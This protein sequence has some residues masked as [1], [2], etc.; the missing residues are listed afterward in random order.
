MKAH[1]FAANYA[2]NKVKAQDVGPRKRLRAAPQ[3]VCNASRSRRCRGGMGYPW[4][5]VY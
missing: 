2:V 5:R 1:I 4:T 3:R